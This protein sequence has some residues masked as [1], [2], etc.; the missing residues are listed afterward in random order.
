MYLSVFKKVTLK[1]LI[2]K[3]EIEEFVKKINNGKLPF[4]KPKTKGSSD[5]INAYFLLNA[6]SFFIVV[7]VAFLTQFIFKF[8]TSKIIYNR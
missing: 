8:L 2:D 3:L 7:I 1:P 6:K 4:I 5:E